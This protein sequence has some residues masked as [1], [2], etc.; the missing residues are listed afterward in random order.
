ME[1]G[2]FSGEGILIPNMR[3]CPETMPA[4]KDNS[5]N[6]SP[7][8]EPPKDMGMRDDQIAQFQSS[9]DQVT[10]VVNNLSK[11]IVATN[12]MFF[13]SHSLPGLP[14]MVAAF[15]TPAE[16]STTNTDT[17]AIMA[18]L[19]STPAYNPTPKHDSHNLNE[20]SLVRSLFSDTKEGSS[21][22]YFINYQPLHAS[23]YDGRTTGISIPEWGPVLF[24]PP[25]G[26]IL[27]EI[28][29]SAI[30]YIYGTNKDNT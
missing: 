25:P 1:H 5:S 9:V 13:P 11:I 15:P 21:S 10:N 12:P 14:V 23:K 7:P 6:N 16:K 28:E 20:P 2:H 8:K 4:N 26:M 30:A 29:A 17:N 27:D 18:K 24:N 3:S 19:S 22:G